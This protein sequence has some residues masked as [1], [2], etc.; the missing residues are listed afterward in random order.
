MKRTTY[1]NIEMVMNS[2]LRTGAKSYRKIQYR[3][4]LSIYEWIF[5]HCPE[6][7]Q[8]INRV[9]RKHFTLY[10]NEHYL[11]TDKTLKEKQKILT[12]FI[13]HAEINV[14]IPTPRKQNGRS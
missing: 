11:E 7:K 5:T 14:R 3:R 9:G 10:F 13:E 1:N 12:Y 6:T 2:Y 8:E 4:L